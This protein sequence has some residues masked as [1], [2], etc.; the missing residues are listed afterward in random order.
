MAINYA[1]K[2]SSL[3]DERF[4]LASVTAEAV[5]QQYDWAGVKTVRVYSIPTAAMQDYERTG[6]Q[7]YGTPGEM[8]QSVQEMQ[9]SRDRSF[10][11]TIDRGNHEET[12][13]TSN[14]ALAL[15]RQLDEVVIPEIDRYRLFVMACGAGNFGTGSIT[16]ATAYESLLDADI[17]LT[18]NNVPPFGRIAFVSPRFYKYILL[19]SAFVKQGDLA[20]NMVMHGA[21]GMVDNIRVIRVPSGYLPAGTEFVLVHPDAVASPQKLAEYKI[22]DNP[23]GINGWLVEGRVCY[24]AFPLKSKTGG[25][26]LH[27]SALGELKLSSQSAGT[28]LTQIIA[29]GATGAQL[30]VQTGTT[31]PALGD[32]LSSWASLGESGV[33]SATNGQDFVV[34]ACIDGLCI[35][36]GTV[37]AVA[38]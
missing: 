9:V 27:Q 12:M 7:R 8:E 33:I 14:A 17:A 19:D 11:F 21:V 6:M 32:D 37:T 15:R 24:D 34:A 16:K 22:H 3:V 10:T 25:I 35:M 4:T 26:Y 1:S 31:L 28:G 18:E 20:Q 2:Y 13:M 5:N 36:A 38:G 23:P 29:E 30:V